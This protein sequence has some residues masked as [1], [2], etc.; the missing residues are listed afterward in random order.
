MDLAAATTA[1]AN[2]CTTNRA[3]V[4]V[5]TPTVNLVER[6]VNYTTSAGNK[7]YKAY[8]LQVTA[9]GTVPP[10]VQMGN[11]FGMLIPGLTGPMTLSATQAVYFENQQA[12]AAD[13]AAS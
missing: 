11:Y 7:T 9:S 2:Y 10:L 12:A 8:F 1:A 13:Y 6:T 5:N 4:S 3:G